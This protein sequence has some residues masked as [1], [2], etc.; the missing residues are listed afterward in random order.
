[1]MMLLA[2]DGGGTR[3]RCLAVDPA[4][5]VRGEGE[6]GPSNHLHVPIAEATDALRQAVAAALSGAGGSMDDVA[7]VS[8]GLAGVDFD[9]TGA[10]EGRDMLRSI[11]LKAVLVHGDMVI[12]HRGA[13]AGAPGVVALAG[14]GSSVLGIADD[15]TMIKAGG[16][17]PLYG[18]EGSAY[19]LGRLGLLAAA[20]AFDRT[21]PPTL[22]LERLTAALGVSDFR[23][24]VTPLY[25]LGGGQQ[26]VAALAEIV[27]ACAAA[28]DETATAICRRAGAE[29]GRTVLAVIPR[30]QLADTL[31]SYHGA[32]LRQSDRVRAAFVDTIQ[33]GWPCASV[34]GPR[35]EPIAGAAR[36]GAEALAWPLPSMASEVS[37]GV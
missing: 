6:S 31:V 1:M 22:L 29:L 17:G 15:G 19:Q 14:T 8:A 37:D 28:G 4:G 27:D 16:W 33:R 10:A 5:V 35:F 9:G 25:S 2:I 26:R 12:A 13:L 3:T 23:E 21:G 11:G 24:T 7:L 30:L 36:L 18:D 34:R 32:V 20:Q